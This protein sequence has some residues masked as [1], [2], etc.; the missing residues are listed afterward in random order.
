MSSNFC[1]PDLSPRHRVIY[2]STWVFSGKIIAAFSGL[3]VNALLTRLLNPAEMGAYFLMFSIV[4]FA[5]V[6]AQLGMKQTVVRVIAQSLGTENPGRARKAVR[7]A[8]L[9]GTV[10]ALV[11]ASIFFFG[12]GPW[13]TRN[14]FDS[15]LMSGVIGLASVWLIVINFQTLLAESFRG[16]HDILLATLFGGLFTSLICALFFALLWLVLGRSSLTQVISLT[17]LAGGTSSIIAGLLLKRKTSNLTGDGELDNRELMT[18]AWPLFITSLA[19]YALS[20]ADLWILGAFR[21]QEDVAIYGAVRRLVAI[22]VMPLTIVNNVVPPLIAEMYAQAK[23]KE[24]EQILRATATVAGIPAFVV[25]SIFI[26]FGGP[27]LAFTYGDFYRQGSTVLILL[28]T[29]QIANVW[30][31]SCGNTLMMTGFQKTMMYITSLCGLIT[32]IGAVWAVKN[33]GLIGVSSVAALSMILQNVLMLLFA[34]KK[35]GIWTNV[36]LLIKY[37]RTASIKQL[38]IRKLI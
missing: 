16:F 2:G 18:V 30:A 8:F 6:F 33:Y 5:A 27:I 32:I 28:S 1:K 11:V 20:N 38:F 3:M 36:G 14:I 22:V 19:L 31:G 4:T 13:L 23:I 12:V 24:L 37:P 26:M 17:I 29:G 35:T 7:L 10:S 34:R 25:L 21:A 9:Y 15:T